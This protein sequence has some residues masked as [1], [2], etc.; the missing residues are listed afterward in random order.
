MLPQANRWFAVEVTHWANEDSPRPRAE[1]KVRHQGSGPPCFGFNRGKHAVVE[2]AILATRVGLI[3]PEEI[4]AQWERLR[5]PL[6]KT[7]GTQERQA[8]ELLER[9][10]AQHLAHRDESI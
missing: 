8:F 5:V 1:C 4:R 10:I 6:E 9:H 3:D 2:A 7:G